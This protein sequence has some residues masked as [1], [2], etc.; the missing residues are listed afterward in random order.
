MKRLLFTNLMIC[1]C[2]LFFSQINPA[3][4]SWLQNTSGIMGSH[5]I[6]G[7]STVIQDNVQ[8]NIQT[9]QYSNNWAYV[10]TNGIPAYP[11]GPF[12]DGNPSLATDQNV[13]F[14]IPLNPAQNTGTLTATTGGNIGIFINGVAL[15][16]YR[17][18]VAWNTSTNSLCGGLPGMSPCP[19]G[20]GASQSWNRDAVPAEKLGFDWQRKILLEENNNKCFKCGLGN[21]WNGA[22]LKLELHHKDGNRTNKIRENTEMLCPNCHSQT[23]TWCGKNK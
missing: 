2:P 12:L 1:S 9:V 13:I 11:T 8:A 22:P 7:N 14:K 20:P 15:F 3:I 21:E 18:G 23:D 17:D 5:Y 4:S 6:S 16:D 19:G 10:T